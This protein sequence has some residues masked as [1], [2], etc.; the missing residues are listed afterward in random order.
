M[1]SDLHARERAEVERSHQE[2]LHATGVPLQVAPEDIT[3]YLDPPI[4]TVFPLEYAYALLGDVRGLT[5]LDFGCGRGE[6]T[7]L[8]AKRGAKVIGM[9]ISASLITLARRRLELNGIP[10]HSADFLVGSAHD[11]PLADGS[12]DVVL[13]IAVLHHLD[14]E[15]ASREVF[16]VLKDGGRAIFQEPVRDSR[17]VRIIRKAIPYRAPDVSPFERPLTSPE[18]RSFASR[19]RT[20]V[21]RAFSLPF[22]NISRVLPVVRQHIKKIYRLDGAVLRRFPSLTWLAGIRVVAL[23]KPSARLGPPAPAAPFGTAAVA[24]SV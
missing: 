17:L 23:S 2:A 10:P 1:P 5:V 20:D 3:R 6:N 15:L 11:I 22:V 8:L 4:N 21:M 24:G 14:L 19:F 16:R 7:L 18:L 13:G 12:V 9:D